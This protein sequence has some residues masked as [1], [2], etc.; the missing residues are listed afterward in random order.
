MPETACM[1]C[2]IG[3][4]KQAFVGGTGLSAAA[5]HVLLQRFGWSTGGESMTAQ[6]SSVPFLVVNATTWRLIADI[7]G[8]IPPGA[9][10]TARRIVAGSNIPEVFATTE[11]HY[12][13]GCSA[14]Q[15]FGQRWLRPVAA[16]DERI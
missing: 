14:L 15:S 6:E 11:R 1:G 10:I 16:A 7:F 3:N 4:S 8:E 2:A 9:H 13:M 5:C 12:V